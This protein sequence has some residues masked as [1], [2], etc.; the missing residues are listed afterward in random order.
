M[1]LQRQHRRTGGRGKRGK[2]IVWS[3]VGLAVWYSGLVGPGQCQGQFELCSPGTIDD[4]FSVG[5]DQRR[6]SSRGSSRRRRSSCG[7]VSR[8]QR[9]L[10]QC[11][12]IYLPLAVNNL[13]KK[14]RPER[15]ACG[16]LENNKHSTDS[17][18][19]LPASSCGARK[20]EIIN[21]ICQPHLLPLSLS[22]SLSLSISLL[23]HLIDIN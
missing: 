9:P 15:Q 18:R 2:L 22:P 23:P 8:L 12:F 3:E 4:S 6:R 20:S 16:H 11:L 19:S 13:C 17:T 14:L 10:H 5:D 1:P 7:I 21:V